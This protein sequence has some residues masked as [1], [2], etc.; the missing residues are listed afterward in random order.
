MTFLRNILRVPSVTK[1]G[2]GQ[3]SCNGRYGSAPGL[4]VRLFRWSNIQYLL[5][6]L[7]IA[8]PRHLL[9]DH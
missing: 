5:E 4:P 2:G 7:R 1:Q 6:S 3:T 8:L 9:V